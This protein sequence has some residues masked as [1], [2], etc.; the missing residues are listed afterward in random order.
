MSKLA[1]RV[2]VLTGRR[3]GPSRGPWR[4]PRS[5]AR[6]VWLSLVAYHSQMSRSEL[7]NIS[8]IWSSDTEVGRL[9]SQPSVGYERWRENLRCT[10]IVLPRPEPVTPSCKVQTQAAQVRRRDRQGQSPPS[11]KRHLPHTAHRLTPTTQRSD[12]YERQYAQLTT[13]SDPRSSCRSPQPCDRPTDRHFSPSTAAARLPGPTLLLNG[14]QAWAPRCARHL[15]CLGS[16][17]PSRAELA[18]RDVGAEDGG[19]KRVGP[20]TA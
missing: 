4:D 19:D 18:N 1:V 7:W 14:R 5:R 6:P 20:E 12:P 15:D 2:L 11:A 13:A 16:S 17:G 10:V 8:P 9:T 3:L